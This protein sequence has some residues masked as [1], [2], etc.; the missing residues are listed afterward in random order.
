MV[1]LLDVVVPVCRSLRDADCIGC[2]LHEG[3]T[4]VCVPTVWYSP[5]GPAL[6]PTRAVATQ[7]RAIVVIGEAPGRAEDLAGLPFSGPS[8]RTLREAY[9]DFFQLRDKA[10]V[11]LTYAARCKVPGKKD[12][13]KSQLKACQGYLLADIRTLQ[14]LYS[15]VIL[16]CVG[17][18][19][20]Q[21][22]TGTS[23]KKWLTQQGTMSHF[24]VLPK[25]NIKALRAT[26]Q[27][28]GG[29][30]ATSKMS[31][32][33][34]TLHLP[35]RQQMF[36]PAPCRVFATY[37]PNYLVHNP[38]AGLAVLSH[39]RLLADYLAG[40]LQMELTHDLDIDVAPLPPTYPI[41]RLALDIETYGFW[42][43]A[44]DQTQFHPR[45]MEAYDRVHRSRIIRTV[46]LSYRDVHG[47]IKNAIFLMHKSD[48][49]RILWSW[50][51]KLVQDKD[52]EFMVGQNLVFDLCCLRHCYP[53]CKAWLDHPLPIMDTIISNYLHDEGRPEKSLK[54]LGSLFRITQYDSASKTHLYE[55]DE[56]QRSWQYNCQDTYT[57]LRLQ[58]KLELEIRSF[59]GP[60][61]AKLSPYCMKWYSELL[62]LLVWMTE[63]GI[64]MDRPALAKLYDKYIMKSCRVQ[65]FALTRW[66]MPLRGKGSEK[67]K[68]TVMFD[69]V[70][71]LDAMG[72]PLPKLEKTKEK[73]DISFCVENRNAL[74]DVLRTF[75]QGRHTEAYKQL[76]IMGLYQD[77]SKILDAYLY[78]LLLGRGK[79]HF[80]PTTKVLNGIAYPKWYP[81]P[82]EYEGG[83]SGGTK[84]AR[85]VCN[86]PACQTFPPA[87]KKAITCR[88]P[89]GYLIWF[90]YSQIE[91]RIAAL[92]SNDPVMCAE[93][94]GKPD[95]HTK[96]ARLVFGDDLTDKF[97]ADQ[98]LKAWNDSQYRHAGKVLNFLMLYLGGA[99]TFRNSLMRDVGLDYPLEKCQAAIEAFR[100]RHARFF[101]WQ[102]ENM[103]FVRKHNFFEL[104]LIGQSRIFMGGRKNIEKSASEVANIPVQ[105]VAAVVMQS[106]QFH[107]WRRCKELHMQAVVPINVYDAAAIECPKFE[108]YQLRTLMAE[109]LPN[110]PYYRDL[111]NHLGRK[112]PME[113]DVRER[114]V[115]SPPVGVKKTVPNA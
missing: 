45:K 55:S 44:P 70:T 12:P 27:L 78:P 34:A 40:T 62:W 72:A 59:Y 107:L 104:P 63:T 74:L 10:D 31:K 73:Q 18:G 54:A 86:G 5:K 99:D 100:R 66:Q 81:V 15:E 75:P 2:G 93:Y 43:D 11:F 114:Q 89:S 53:E 90:D 92:L 26:L 57:T 68:R 1:D 108:I 23:M 105:A 30:D 49:R 115:G 101:E 41:K 21:S 22:V 64:A 14:S 77:Y 96:T 111:C 28:L 82:S 39:T 6:P 4:T 48:H 97:I 58:E 98:G 60:T 13:T 83:G 7:D 25:G 38:T 35:V 37:N 103:A 20:V 71:V 3:A 61:T 94:M 67:S 79:N 102:S 76:V 52:F 109:I 80:D 65:D 36:Y 29:G 69:A 56:D 46:G 95:L 8:G 32:A 110:P 87:V 9:I 42:K 50:F 47:D 19:A 33:D 85:I 91:L 88:F 106:A 84:Q 51:R 113:Y 24:E 16:L 112:L 17:G